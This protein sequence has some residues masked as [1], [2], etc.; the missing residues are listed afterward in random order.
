MRLLGT[1][2]FPLLSLAAAAVCIVRASMALSRA[3][4]GIETEKSTKAS[5]GLAFGALCLCAALWCTFAAFVASF[6]AG[7]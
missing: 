2:V 3:R 7:C 6:F 1:E 4:R 5:V